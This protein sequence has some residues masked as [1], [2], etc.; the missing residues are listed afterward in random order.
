MGNVST[1]A[2]T[3]ALAAVVNGLGIVRLLTAFAEYLRRRE[4]IEVAHYWVYTLLL[5]LQFL[6]HVLMWWAMYGTSKAGTLNFLQYLYLLAGPILLF[7][8]T[9][10]LLPDVDDEA[11]DLR[12]QYARLAPA[13]FLTIAGLWIWAVFLWP[14]LVGA[15]AP[16]WPF[17]AGF[18]VLSLTLAFVNARFHPPLIVVYGGAILVFIAL[19]QIQLGKVA[20][21]VV[22]GLP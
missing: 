15:F 21:A 3:I 20:G 14:V 18:A 7:L 17:L 8:A 12:Q 11:I 1:F 22:D 2:F 10:L 9:S 16:P 4:S 5:C 19:Y 6:L 13:H